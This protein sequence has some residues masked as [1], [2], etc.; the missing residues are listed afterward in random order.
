MWIESEIHHS[1]QQVVFAQIKK[2]IMLDVVHFNKH[3][4]DFDNLE[5]I[6]NK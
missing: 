4:C 6:F 5:H 3:C 2:T 1:K